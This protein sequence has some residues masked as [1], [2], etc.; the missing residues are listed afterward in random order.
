MGQVAA[1]GR[2]DSQGDSFWPPLSLMFQRL[3]AA[4]QAAEIFLDSQNLFEYPRL[5]SERDPKPTRGGY[6]VSHA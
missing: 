4:L 1:V 5:A 6:H 2:H 3:R